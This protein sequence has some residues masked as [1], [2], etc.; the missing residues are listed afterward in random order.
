MD[1]PFEFIAPAGQFMRL[2]CSDRYISLGNPSFGIFLRPGTFQPVLGPF[3]LFLPE[4]G[5]ANLMS[6]M[7]ILG[8]E[9][10]VRVFESRK[11]VNWRVQSLET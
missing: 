1:L 10:V 6:V 7:A 5:M 4:K 8:H 3:G 11:T 9:R 2:I